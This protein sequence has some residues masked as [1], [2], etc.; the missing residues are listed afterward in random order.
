[1]GLSSI[2]GFKS[3]VRSFFRANKKP[4]TGDRIAAIS[5]LDFRG[6]ERLNYRILGLEA[7]SSDLFEALGILFIAGLRAPGIV[8]SGRKLDVDLSGL[9]RSSSIS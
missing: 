4:K 3:A 6:F 2:A 1:M 9:E 7:P 5:R 8:F